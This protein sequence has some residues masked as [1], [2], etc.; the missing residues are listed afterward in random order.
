MIT[1]VVIILQLMNQQQNRPPDLLKP[2]W[3]KKWKQ[4]VL[5]DPLHTHRSS[6]KFNRKIMYEITT[7]P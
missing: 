7:D 1:W 6:I 2:A 5:D 3:S 4:M